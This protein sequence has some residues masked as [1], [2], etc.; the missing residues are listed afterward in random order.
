MGKLQGAGR[1]GQ[2]EM[3]V[4]L[5]FEPLVDV[6]ALGIFPGGAGDEMKMAGEDARIEVDEPVGSLVGCGFGRSGGRFLLGNFLRLVNP[7]GFQSGPVDFLEVEEADAV[8]RLRKLRASGL[9]SGRQ[10]EVRRSIQD[11]TL[12]EKFAQGFVAAGAENEAGPNGQMKEV[13]LR[14]AG[15][16]LAA[17][18]RYFQERGV[19]FV[20]FGA[21]LIAENAADE[22]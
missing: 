1:R 17:A 7:A 16:A 2:P 18:E 6:Q 13:P 21:Q 22:A 8:Q 3:A 9:K 11:G 19:A 14:D 5:L 4:P 12:G 10:I 15:A 20:T